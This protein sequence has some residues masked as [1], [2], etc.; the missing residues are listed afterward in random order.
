MEK[1]RQRT[2]SKWNSVVD[3]I[4]CVYKVVKVETEPKDNRRQTK[5]ANIYGEEQE[6]GK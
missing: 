5:L 4:L 6:K 2:T 1:I 3:N